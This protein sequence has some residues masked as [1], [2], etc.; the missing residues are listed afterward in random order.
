MTDARGA[1]DIGKILGQAYHGGHAIL[2]EAVRS[3]PD[4]VLKAGAERVIDAVAN[5]AIKRAG[6]PPP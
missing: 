5:A 2:A 1:W 3:F 6:A 4:E